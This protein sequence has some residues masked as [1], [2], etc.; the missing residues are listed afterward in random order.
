MIASSSDRSKRHYTVTCIAGSSAH[1]STHA[2]GRQISEPTLVTSKQAQLFA[3]TPAACANSSCAPA[4]QQLRGSAA[5]AATAVGLFWHR[6]H[7]S[8]QPKSRPR[9]VANI[10]PGSSRLQAARARVWLL[11]VQLAQL[12]A[13]WWLQDC[14]PGQALPGT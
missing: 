7:R 3:D 12:G 4:T 6:V 1:P 2:S 10:G 13:D 5:A 9:H 11:A 8:L 14:R